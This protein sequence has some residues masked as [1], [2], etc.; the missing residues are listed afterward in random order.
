MEID[1]MEVPN[2]KDIN[3]NIEKSGLV[4]CVCLNQKGSESLVCPSYYYLYVHRYMYLSNI[5]PKCLEFF[6]SF[7]LPFY[8]NKFGVYFECIKKEEKNESSNNNN[9]NVNINVNTN[10]NINTNVNT[11]INTNPYSSTNNCEEKIVLDWRLPIGVLF[12]IYCDLNNIEKEYTT[13]HKTYNE[14][15]VNKKK[16]I[17]ICSNNELYLNHI[18]IVKLEGMN[19]NHEK[20]SYE[21][22]NEKNIY[23][24]NV[25]IYNNPNNSSNVNHH[26]NCNKNDDHIIQKNSFINEKERKG[27]IDIKKE[28]NGNT[29]N[30]ESEK[31][32]QVKNIIVENY[33]EENYMKENK[34]HIDNDKGHI[35]NDI[36]E[37]KGDINEYYDDIKLNNINIYDD[38]TKFD[39]FQF[40][41]NEQIN[42]EWY[43]KQFVNIS[44]KNIPWVLIVHFK[45]DE[46]YPLSLN[47][48]KYD[49]KN[50]NLKGDINI[51]PYNNYIPLYKGFH[52]FEEFI[53]NQLKKANYIL[54]KN[55]RALEILPQRIQKD[56]L[57][58]LK[59]FHIEKICSLY[60][61]YID[62]NMLNFINYFNNSYIKKVK[63]LCDLNRYKDNSIQTNQKISDKKNEE[64]LCILKIDPQEEESQVI[65]I[66]Q[67]DNIVNNKRNNINNNNNNNN[68]SNIYCV[69]LNENFI[70][71]QTQKN[72]VSN[73]RTSYNNDNVSDP[74]NKDIQNDFSSIILEDTK[75]EGDHINFKNNLHHNEKYPNIYDILKDEKVIKD[76]PIILHIYGPP[77]NQ[78]L[79]KY[80]FIK[81]IQSNDNIN[82]NNNNMN[83]NIN[84]NINKYD[85]RNMYIQNILLNTLG[86]FLHDQI[87][88]FVRK[89]INKDEKNQTSHILNN[90]DKDNYLNS[91]TIY[92]FIED[93]YLIF[94]PYMFIIINGI[95]IPL[96]TPLYWLAANFS[97]FDHFLHIT[98]RIPPY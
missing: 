45:G 21:R 53:I 84:N 77:Y 27:S 19:K 6:K 89:I 41:K 33:Y 43:N 2:I 8:G 16:S 57:Y 75:K 83:N 98:I 18:N 9:M 24:V 35:K 1:Y 56:I 67:C 30:E 86:D 26:Q 4:L 95:Q 25:N 92:Y 97:Q 71:D 88:S 65:R 64:N 14:L 3:S 55:N 54:N 38:I 69:H 90:N 72:N 85:S 39:Y 51:L 79:T 22:Y 13:N 7:I 61:E 91:E 23:D 12:D 31:E 11:N 40:V 87:P 82:N 44:N 36:E 59:Q 62:Y 28:I 50:T 70:N 68:I 20:L 15:D 47:N 58:N 34:I 66:E 63:Q 73:I 17:K 52:N 32:R 29:K 94:S 37:N 78:I 5:I 81:V 42:N 46:E 60:R 10:V 76:C 48:K 80:P 49:E 93:D 74:L 96:N